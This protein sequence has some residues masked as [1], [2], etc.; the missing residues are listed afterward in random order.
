MQHLQKTGARGGSYGLRESSLRIVI[1]GGQ[2]AQTV[3][4]LTHRGIILHVV[5]RKLR[6]GVRRGFLEPRESAAED[7]FHHV[8][9][10]VALLGDSHFRARVAG[11]L[12]RRTAAGVRLSTALLASASVLPGLKAGCGIWRARFGPWTNTA[13]AAA[14]PWRF[15]GKPWPPGAR[16]ESRYFPSGSA[17]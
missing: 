15:P 5:R 2:F 3:A 10:P 16:L 13:A 7:E 11:A 4:E 14:I 8:G 17:P 6:E 12:T 9:W 1:P